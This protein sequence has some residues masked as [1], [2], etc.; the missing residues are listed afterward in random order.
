M[1]GVTDDAVRVIIVR[2]EMNRYEKALAVLAGIGMV[3]W[4]ALPPPRHYHL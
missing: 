1:S 3:V 4:L 2:K